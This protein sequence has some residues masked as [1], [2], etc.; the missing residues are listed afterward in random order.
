MIALPTVCFD[1]P[2]PSSPKVL[3]ILKD[4]GFTEDRCTSVSHECICVCPLRALT[5]PS[6]F[7]SQVLDILKDC[8]FTEDRFFIHCDGAL[9]GM[10]MPFLKEDAPMVTFKKPIGSVSVSGH[11]FVGAPVPCGVVITRFKYVMAL[12]S[13]VE[14]LNSRDATIMGSRNGHA[15]IYLWYTLTR[16]G[17][18]GMRKDVE[19]CMRNAETLKVTWVAGGG[20]GGVLRVCLGRKGDA[21]G[22]GRGRARRPRQGQ[23]GGEG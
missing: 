4:C 7:P 9:F 15:P 11:K 5:G 22:R 18:E 13:D 16:K 23:A 3:D 2:R 6:P 10:M 1:C 17:Y 21:A 14:Y 8:G 12:S 19:R 20:G